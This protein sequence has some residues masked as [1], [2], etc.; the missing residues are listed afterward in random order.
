MMA[1]IRYDSPNTPF[2]SMHPIRQFRLPDLDTLPEMPEEIRDAAERFTRLQGQVS[3]ADLAVME[4]QAALEQARTEDNRD[5]R[6]AIREGRAIKSPRGRETKAQAALADAE[7]V[8]ADT[9]ALRE[10]AAAELIQA[11][12]G[13]Q[14]AIA[15]RVAERVGPLEEE[16]AELSRKAEPIR[17]ERARLLEWTGLVYEDATYERG[18]FLGPQGTRWSMNGAETDDAGE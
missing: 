3:D 16:L 4:A 13:H 11:V 15:E 9:L 17:R 8:Q 12:V 1:R 6:D 18:E 2:G 10:E 7:A 14:E 5:R